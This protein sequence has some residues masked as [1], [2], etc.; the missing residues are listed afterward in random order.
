MFHHSLESAVILILTEPLFARSKEDT[1]GNQNMLPRNEVKQTNVT[2]SLI[3]M[4]C[5]LN[6]SAYDLK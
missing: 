1:Y 4:G 3:G 5:G 6:P 2:C